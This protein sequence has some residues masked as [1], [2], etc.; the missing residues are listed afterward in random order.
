MGK[1]RQPSELGPGWDLGRDWG[2]L[3]TPTAAGVCGVY[4]Q[5]W[6]IKKMICVEFINVTGLSRTFFLVIQMSDKDVVLVGGL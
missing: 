1:A 3:T 2:L 6:D 4:A 5:W